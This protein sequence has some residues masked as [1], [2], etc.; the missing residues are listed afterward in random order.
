[1]SKLNQICNLVQHGE[2]TVHFQGLGGSI[3]PAN[4]ADGHA[5]SIGRI[6]IDNGV[7]AEKRIARLCTE[8]RE[9]KLG[10]RWVRFAGALGHAAKDRFEVSVHA[11]VTEY[12]L[13]KKLGLVGTDRHPS[14]RPLKRAERVAH[15]RKGQ[16]GWNFDR[17]MSRSEL[18]KV[19]SR[20]DGER[21]HDRGDHRFAANGVHC[22]D[23][24][25]VGRLWPAAFSQH[26]VN[27]MACELRTVDK[28]AVEVEDDIAIAHRPHL[29]RTRVFA[30]AT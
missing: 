8:P 20:I 30:A 18:L 4:Q 11:V 10:A 28:R 5:S 15:A 13:A 22:T 1:M 25:T 21:N 2:V 7:S 12:L 14:L 29:N 26:L 27:E 23:E 16:S 3:S 19:G 17:A 6:H 24:C 9:R